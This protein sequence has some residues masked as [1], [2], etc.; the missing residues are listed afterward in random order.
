MK[1]ETKVFYES[2]QA[3]LAV[4]LCVGSVLCASETGSNEDLIEEPFTF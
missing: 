1:K 4:P 3:R 2:P